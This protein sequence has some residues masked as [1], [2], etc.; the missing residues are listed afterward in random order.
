MISVAT[1]DGD[2]VVVIPTGRGTRRYLAGLFLVFWLGA[3]AVGFLQAGRQLLSGSVE[4]FLIFW[5]A[6]W[7]IAGLWTAYLV[8][9]LLRP[10]IPETLRLGATRL[11]YD[12]GIAPPDVMF[13]FRYSSGYEAW[14]ALF[15]KRTQLELERSK[16]QSLHLRETLAGNRLTLDVDAVRLDLAQTA[17]EIDREWLYDVLVQRY[18]LS[19]GSRP[20][21]AAS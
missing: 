16:L 7:T 13:S 12:S 3:W 4:A 5:L 19:H 8:Y 11:T 20:T 17:S 9:R 21:P 2:P 10:A 1:E 15:R 14:K 18:S 6:L